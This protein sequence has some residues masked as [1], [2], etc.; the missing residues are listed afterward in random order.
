MTPAAIERAVERTGSKYVADVQALFD[1]VGALYEAQLAAQDQALAARAGQLA[2]QGE[3]I[4]ALR[5]RAE[6]AEA[7]RDELRAQ[8]AEGAMP[9]VA[10]TGERETT[11]A[12]RARDTPPAAHRPAQG[13]WQRL[14]RRLGEE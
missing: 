8:P 7:E 5:R 2:A 6:V 4:A 10:P 9:R 3:T 11:E 14:R 1:R 12:P 13:R